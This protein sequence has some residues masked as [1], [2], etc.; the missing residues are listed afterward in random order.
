MP[1][2]K[3]VTKNNNCLNLTNKFDRHSSS[4]KSLVKRQ[5]LVNVFKLW[6]IV[7]AVVLERSKKLLRYGKMA[8]DVIVNQHLIFLRR[9][10]SIVE[11]I[12]RCKTNKLNACMT[13]ASENLLIC[14]FTDFIIILPIG[15]SSSTRWIFKT[16]KLQRCRWYSYLIKFTWL[17]FLG[18]LSDKKKNDAILRS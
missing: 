13:Q 8:N 10:I 18:Y 9:F 17:K 2:T 11:N 6:N 3:E 12:C 5:P 15:I 7:V 4:F 16:V 1:P 14:G